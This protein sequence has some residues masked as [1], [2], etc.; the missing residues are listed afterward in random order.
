MDMSIS[1]VHALKS[2]DGVLPTGSSQGAGGGKAHDCHH[3]CRVRMGDSGIFVLASLVRNI[4]P[5]EK[6]VSVL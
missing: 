4:F 3:L 5:G 2:W 6:K 1:R